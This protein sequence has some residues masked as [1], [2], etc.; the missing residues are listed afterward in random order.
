MGTPNFS[1]TPS[2]IDP[3]VCVT[4]RHAAQLF[5]ISIQLVDKYL[6]CGLLPFYRFGNSRRILI[7]RAD[8]EKLLIPGGR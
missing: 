4:R 5:D 1:K 2:N 3:R 8:L 6:A 7:R